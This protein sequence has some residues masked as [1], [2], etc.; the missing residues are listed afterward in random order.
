MTITINTVTMPPGLM[1]DDEYKWSAVD[2]QMTYST[3]GNPLFDIGVKQA[4]R[5]MTLIPPPTTNW[6][7]RGE[8]K[9]LL[10][11][12]GVPGADIAVNF[13]GRTFICRFSYEDKEGPIQVEQ[14]AKVYPEEDTDFFEIKKICLL[15]KEETTGQ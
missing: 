6:I 10:A 13:R 5:P 1:W 9:E 11:M 15:I 3:T 14:L 2:Q 8:V 12:A 7:T 4:G